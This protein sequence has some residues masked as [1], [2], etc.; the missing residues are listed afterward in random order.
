VFAKRT[1]LGQDLSL[2]YM[3]LISNTD[4]YDSMIEHGATKTEA[5]IVSLGSMAGMFAVD[6][7]LG[8]GEMFFDDEEAAARRMYRKSLTESLEK[9]VA[10][11]IGRLGTAPEI[12]R[13]SKN[14]LLNLFNKGKESAS[15]FIK[16][17]RYQIK[18]RSLGIFG[19]SVGEGLEEV[20]EELV[21][22]MMKSLYQVAGQF[23]LASQTDVGAWA[24][25]TDRYL[26]SFFGGAIGGA[27]FG[28]VDAIK[29]PKTA[30]D[31]NS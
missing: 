30:A 13:D 28:A 10:P 25:A 5:A 22:D 6:K 3:A 18:D 12:E 20:S 11:S 8:L 23:G 16:D 29:N 17:Y 15:K 7:Y 31:K 2:M 24:N 19:K 26:M 14:T 9:D 21:T 4:V 27:M 1:R